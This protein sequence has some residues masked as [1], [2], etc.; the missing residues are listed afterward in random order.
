MEPVVDDYGCIE[1]Y[2]CQKCLAEIEKSI[3]EAYEDRV[4]VYG[5]AIL[6]PDERKSL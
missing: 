2:F 3:A 6:F 4:K 1:G 5:K